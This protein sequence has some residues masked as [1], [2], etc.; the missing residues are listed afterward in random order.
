LERVEREIA[1]HPDNTRAMALGA[2]AL[3]YL[4]EKE[5]AKEWASRA[6]TIEP[7]DEVDHYNIVCSFAQMGEPDQAL[8]VLEPSLRRAPPN[9]SRGSR[10]IPI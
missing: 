9:T 10:E 8:D 7:D 5:R 6:L 2:I 3:A 1:L 4:G